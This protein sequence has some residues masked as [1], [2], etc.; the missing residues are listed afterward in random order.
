M[1]NN[2]LRTF[3]GIPLSPAAKEMLRKIQ[4]DLQR[5]PIFVKWVD[6][7][8]IHLTLKFL[9]EITPQK[10]K[11]IQTIFPSLFKN[12]SSFEITITHLGAFPDVEKPRIIWAGISQ[13][14][15]RLTELAQKIENDLALFGFPKE[16]QE[17]TPHLTIG[18]VR[19]LKNIE[20]IAHEISGKTIPPITQTID[21]VVLFKSILTSQG[22]IYEYLSEVKL[23]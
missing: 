22:P 23:M 12:S 15:E 5:F 20:T 8:N 7:S 17:F 18:R 6:S 9:G 10:L 3:I 13:N 4:E 2:T 21:T 1:N 14:A 19:S 11:S 16:D